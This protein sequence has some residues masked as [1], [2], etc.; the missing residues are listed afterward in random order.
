MKEQNKIRVLVVE[1]DYLV[2]EMIQG[3][4]E[5]VGFSF[6]GGVADGQEAVEV[7]RM[8]KPDLVLMDIALPTIDGIEA[9]RR[10]QEQ[11][12]T[13][14]VALT[15]FESPDLVSRASKAG[16][17]AYLVKPINPQELERAIT[18][19]VARFNDMMELRRLNTEL[20]ARTTAL[21]NTLAEIKVLKGLIPICAYC[22]KVRDDRGYWEKV[23]VYLKNNSEA[24]F[25][26]CFCPDCCQKLY[27]DACVK[28]PKTA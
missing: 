9:T 24:E 12:P 1:D 8:L 23:E 25:T 10:I 17:G 16:V 7:T 28:P 2:R 13:P 5:E 22:K 27:P 26:H 15:A 14:V 19:A 4:L 20:Q 11:C 3:L 6:A 21:E 18:I